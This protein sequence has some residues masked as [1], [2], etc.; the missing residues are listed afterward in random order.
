M[1]LMILIAAVIL[2]YKIFTNQ[3]ITINLTNFLRQKIIKKEMFTHVSF[4]ELLVSTGGYG[5]SRVSVRSENPVRSKNLADSGLRSLGINVLAIVRGSE[6]LAN[7]TAQ[8]T[9]QVGDELICFGKL[10]EIRHHF[11]PDAKTAKVKHGEEKSG[12]GQ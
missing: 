11:C 3:K 12:S 8:T 6:T 2:V 5:I 1:N 10:D 4:E 9:I 7:P